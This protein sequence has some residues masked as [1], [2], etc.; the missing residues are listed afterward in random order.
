M[1][2]IKL[3]VPLWCVY[4]P[5]CFPTMFCFKLRSWTSDNIDFQHLNGIYIWG[6]SIYRG[7]PGFRTLG[8]NFENW[9]ESI[10][11]PL[12]FETSEEACKYLKVLVTPLL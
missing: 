2:E 3:D 10:N 1:E 4:G 6:Y 11:N 5:D 9:K 12:F 7:E 8:L